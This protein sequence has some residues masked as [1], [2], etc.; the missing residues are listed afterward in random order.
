MQ[1]YLL[2]VHNKVKEKIIKKEL[3]F[4]KKKEKKKEFKIPFI[5]SL[6]GL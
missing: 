1:F 6:S 4:L 5:I 3:S 2:Y